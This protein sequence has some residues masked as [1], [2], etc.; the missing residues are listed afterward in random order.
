MYQ[1]LLMTRL[2]T[3]EVTTPA[4]SLWTPGKLPGRNLPE[5]GE[6]SYYQKINE[7]H[8]TINVDIVVVSLVSI[9]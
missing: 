3:T 2:I 6:L 9:Y 4:P 8:N 5:L 1:N 7:K